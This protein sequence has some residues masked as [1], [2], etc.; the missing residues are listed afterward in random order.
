MNLLAV[1]IGGTKISAGV[2]DD[3]GTL[4]ERED[5]ATP[6][7]ANAEQLFELVGRLVDRVRDGNLAACGVGCGG[8]MTS[9]G[10]DVSPLNIPA[11]H[12]FPLRSRLAAHT[13]LD[14][15]VDNDAK[16]LALGEG[17]V[18]GARGERD[19]LG[20]VVSTGVGGGIV[21]DGRLLDVSDGGGAVL[22]PT[23]SLHP[24]LVVHV[25]FASAGGDEVARW[26]WGQ[27]AAGQVLRRVRDRLDA[28][29][30]TKTVRTHASEP[31]D[32]C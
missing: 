29:A 9:W 6:L 5:E 30:E 10:D 25:V 1:D 7:D 3:A 26:F 18:G 12:A 13:G 27:T 24:G 2:V 15:F 16:A 8:P 28:S 31:Q 22:V 14:V 23:G 17:W 32:G 21:L 20:M 19:Y 11:W 4:L